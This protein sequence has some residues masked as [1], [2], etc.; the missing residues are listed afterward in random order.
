MLAF[1]EFHQLLRVP[2]LMQHFQQHRVTDPQMSFAHF[3]KIHYLAP[4]PLND[5]FN[6]HQQLP[7][8]CMDCQVMN[9][10][11]YV[12]TSVTVEIHPP[13]PVAKQF[14]RYNETNKPQFSAFDIF[15]PPRCA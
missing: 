14:Y 6:Q 1:T 2:Y 15:Q 13:I 5:D 10:A 8:R 7:F 4:V 12:W 3:I 11:V 9:A